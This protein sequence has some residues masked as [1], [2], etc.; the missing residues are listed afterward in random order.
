MRLLRIDSSAPRSSVS[1]QLTFRFTDAWRSAH[2]EGEISYRD[3]AA[4]H[5][6]PITDDWSAASADPSL[7]TPDQRRYLATS[8]ALI[9]ELSAADL[10]PAVGRARRR[11]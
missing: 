11:T 6:P 9:A 4:S 10:S 2:P 1:R 5:L 7:W 8:D 3:L